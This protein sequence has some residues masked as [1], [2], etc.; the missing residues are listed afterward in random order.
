MA[1][2]TEEEE[3]ERVG[4]ENG[5]EVVEEEDKLEKGEMEDEDIP[6]VADNDSDND[7]FEGDFSNRNLHLQKH[8]YLS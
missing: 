5:G 8:Y 2:E 3:E 1:P 6:V 7:V 4:A